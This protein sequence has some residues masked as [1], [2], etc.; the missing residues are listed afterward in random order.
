MTLGSCKPFE[1][2]VLGVCLIFAVICMQHVGA[3]ETQNEGSQNFFTEFKIVD[4]TLNFDALR[5]QVW[6]VI[7]ALEITL[8]SVKDNLHINN[9][10]V[11][12]GAQLEQ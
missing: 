5:Q 6:S 1:S 7:D 12:N 3:Q 4:S 11:H 9:I 10:T 2:F 8:Q